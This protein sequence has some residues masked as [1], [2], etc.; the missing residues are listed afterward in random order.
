MEKTL[1]TMT[2]AYRMVGVV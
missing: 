1:L 2:E